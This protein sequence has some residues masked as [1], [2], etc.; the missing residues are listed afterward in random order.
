MWNDTD[1]P[2]AYLITFRCY[3]TWLHGD[4]RGSTD[5]FHNAYKSPHI[6]A[7]DTWKQHNMRKLRS[8]PLTL[9][10]DQRQSVERAIQETCA[11]RHWH[12]QALNARTNHVHLVISIGQTKPG[13]ALN[14]LKANATRQ[15]RED[16]NWQEAHSPW[17]DKGSQ[18]YL[19]NEH[20]VGLA[21]DY[22]I[23]G[24]GDKLPDWD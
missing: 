10:A 14:A 11:Q 2:L 7:N 24:Q 6:V 12:L 4:E 13:R 18:R 23:N 9:D 17:A 5:R 21:L 8:D 3:G 19:W 15:M 1:L 22:V 20:S 16:G